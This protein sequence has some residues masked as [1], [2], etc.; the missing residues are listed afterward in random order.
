[1][2]TGTDKIAQAFNE[3]GYFVARGLLKPLVKRLTAEFDD[4]VDRLVASGEE[5]D[6]TW[7]GAA[8]SRLKAKSDKILHT[9]NV[10]KYSRAWLDAFLDPGL[11]DVAG[12]CMGSDNIILHHSKLFQKPAE[13][14]SPFPIHQDWPYFPT[15]N[16]SMIAG[17][18]HV[19]EAS[20]EM[21]CLRV[22]P[23]SHRLGRINDSNG[24][25]SGTSLTDYPIEKA[26]PVECEPGD[27]IFFHY[28]TLHGSMPNRSD[29][30]RKTVLF[31]IYDGE[32]KIELGNQHPDERLVLRGRNYK[33][34]RARAG[35]PGLA[36]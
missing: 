9:H 16:D 33:I 25:G 27:V 2:I 6:A 23:G 10:Q 26:I 12:A 36:A 20:D 3:Q 8:N 24:R 19:S 32:D 17:I 7:E 21:G 15:Q 4:I 13:N 34:S 18:V 11:L 14:G 29:K 1:M 5:I 31:Q 35:E 30:T 28:F 22:H